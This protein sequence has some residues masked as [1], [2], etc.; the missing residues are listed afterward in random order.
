VASAESASREAEKRRR[1][2]EDFAPRYE[3]TRPSGER[4]ANKFG[5]RAPGRR[6]SAGGNVKILLP[7]AKVQGLAGNGEQINPAAGPPGGVKAPG[8]NVKI[9]LPDAKAQ[10][11]AGRGEQRNPAAGPL[12]GAKEAAA[13]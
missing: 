13:M 12:G 8:G 11:L 2:C 9:L 6:Q 1:Q 3:G 10:G 5:R 4:G 7:D